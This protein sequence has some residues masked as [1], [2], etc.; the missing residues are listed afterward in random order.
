MASFRNHYHLWANATFNLGHQ[1]SNH[2]L[3]DQMLLNFDCISITPALFWNY[4]SNSPDSFGLA[5]SFYFDVC[6]ACLILCLLSLNFY[7]SFLNLAIYITYSFYI[8]QKIDFKYRCPSPALAYLAAI[9]D[10]QNLPKLAFGVP[11]SFS[12]NFLHKMAAFS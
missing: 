8:A 7:Y 5:I 10:Y 11:P 3:A 6:F 12:N 1:Y 4:R 9:L 2:C